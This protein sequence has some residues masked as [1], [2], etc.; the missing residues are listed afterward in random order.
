MCFTK[1]SSDSS[2]SLNIDIEATGGSILLDGG[3]CC[4]IYSIKGVSSSVSSLTL[5]ESPNSFFSSCPKYL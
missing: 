1:P 3:P 4:L 2:Q 5:T